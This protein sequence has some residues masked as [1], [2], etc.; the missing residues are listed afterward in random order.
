MFQGIKPPGAYPVSGTAA[1]SGLP[2]P[3]Q[4]EQTVKQPNFDQFQLSAQPNSQEAT[5]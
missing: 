1:H 3:T 2:T 5:V 4:G